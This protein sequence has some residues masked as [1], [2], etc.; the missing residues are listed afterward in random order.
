MENLSKTF[1]EM[2]SIYETLAKNSIEWDD[3]NHQIKI[4]PSILQYPYQLFKEILFQSIKIIQEHTG[5]HFSI[6]NRCINTT[7]KSLK[8]V[9]RP[10]MK[11][12]LKTNTETGKC[13][14]LIFN[15]NEKPEMKLSIM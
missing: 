2:Y 7:F 4:Q 6:T 14:T 11:F 13:L 3:T 8:S 9:T 15:N 1:Q 5:I 10:M 12:N